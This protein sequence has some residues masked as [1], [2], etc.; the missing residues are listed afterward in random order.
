[1]LPLKNST[2]SAKR[3]GHWWLY[4]LLA[5]LLSMAAIFL[6][7]YQKYLAGDKWKPV[8]QKSLSREVLRSS[9]GLYHITY[10]DVKLNILAGNVNI[11]NFQ[12]IPDTA[13]YNRLVAGKRAPDNLFI[14][15]VKNLSVS[16]AGAAKA[17]LEKR[18]DIDSIV[19][20]QP[21]VTIINKR[22][23]YN[24]TAK[25]GPPKSFYEL[26]KKT[27]KEIRVRS[28]SLKNVSVD[29]IDKNQNTPQ[30]TVLTNMAVK[31][32]DILID[33]LSGRDTS[34]FY[35]TK[36][37]QIALKGYGFKTPDNLYQATV[38]K[39]TFNTAKKQMIINKAALI[40]RYNNS[41]FIK[42]AGGSGDIY[43]LRFNK[44]TLN[45]LDLQRFLVR[46]EVFAA[47]M[48]ITDSY[49]GVYEND[50]NAGK[51]SV[52]TGRD[53]QQLLQ[54]VKLPLGVNRINISNANIA[55]AAIDRTS[56][57]TGQVLFTHTSGYLKNVTNDSVQKKH[58]PF[59][60]AHLDTRFMDEAS[61]SLKFKFNLNSATGAFNYSGTLG[62]YDARKL[63]KLV[64]PLA[65]VHIVSGDIQKLTFNINAD[66]Y[67]SKGLVNFYYRNLNIQLLKKE[68]GNPKL[69]NKPLVSVLAN[70]FV[71]EDNNPNANG[72]FRPGPL[73]LQRGPTVSFFAY[74]YRGILSG[75]KASVGLSFKNKNAVTK[76]V[77]NIASFT[78]K[79]VNKAQNKLSGFLHKLHNDTRKN[80]V[81]GS[82]H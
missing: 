74:L 11:S 54:K 56:R 18:L 43:T 7:F 3:H 40:P 23:A 73:F 78:G 46:R 67:N 29:Y 45:N 55:F 68:D 71:L 4:I 33:S 12:L 17:Y 52:K 49:V 20:N 47:G 69:K 76:A 81:K 57:Q 19:I 32:T 51:P 16:D 26:I 70:D 44:I 8:L 5:V 42:K 15:S 59:L 58:N 82:K 50:V 22:F 28:V 80:T 35:Y 64:K 41:D 65:L 61:L 6:Y 13:V 14:I 25:A 36:N 38:G 9:A 37:V 66:N 48:D 30:S 39:L 27:F 79:S 24:D 75:V 62:P 77:V 60:T 72:A 63:D 34:R 10:S 21:K 2:T 1:M 53:P 31:V